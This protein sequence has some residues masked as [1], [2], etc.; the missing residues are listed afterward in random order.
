MN[1]EQ[2][3][4]EVID[5]FKELQINDWYCIILGEYEWDS[6]EGLKKSERVLEE[7]ID[8][9]VKHGYESLINKCKHDFWMLVDGP[10]G[11]AIET[12]SVDIDQEVNNLKWGKDD[13][14]YVDDLYETIKFDNTI[15]RKFRRIIKR[16]GLEYETLS[17]GGPTVFYE[18]INKTII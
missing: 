13:K 12:G 3:V 2:L 15:N 10:I 6:F 9:R 1:N 5:M 8:P 14:W 18:K 16:Y 7:Y 17:M 4:C 11:Y